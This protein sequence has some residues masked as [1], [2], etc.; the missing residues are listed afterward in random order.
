MADKFEQELEQLG[1]AEV[2][3]RLATKAYLGAKASLALAWLERRSEA[4]HS[5]QAA[6]AREAM[7]AA[8][9][10]ARAAET[11]NTRATIAITVAIASAVIAIVVGVIPFLL[12]P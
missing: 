5:E 7:D 3:S 6:V 11:A 2:R 1:A 12:K 8:W 4:S 9:A 10:A